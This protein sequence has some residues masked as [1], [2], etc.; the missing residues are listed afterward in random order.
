MNIL[1]HAVPHTHA[2]AYKHTHRKER[3]EK[4]KRVGHELFVVLKNKTANDILFQKTGWQ[5]LQVDSI[6][7]QRNAPTGGK[8]PAEAQRWTWEFT[9]SSLPLL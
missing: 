6:F 3:K 2:H 4:N 9:L 1:F 7:D 8:T 5:K